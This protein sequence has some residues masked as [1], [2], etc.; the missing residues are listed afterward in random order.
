MKNY[1]ALKSASKASVAKAKV[2]T[3]AK[4][5]E[6]K[7]SDGNVTTEAVAEESHEELQLTLK[8]YD[9]TTGEE[10]DDAVQSYGLTQVAHEIANCKSIVAGKQ[11]EQADWEE[12]EKDLKAL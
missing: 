3:T 1:K 11:S 9:S 8:S 12:L 10:L 5:D 6:V 4:V 7:D 2:I